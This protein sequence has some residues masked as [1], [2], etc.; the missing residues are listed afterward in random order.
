MRARR[1]GLKESGQSRPRSH[2]DASYTCLPMEQSGEQRGTPSSFL[3]DHAR[4]VG[5]IQRKEIVAGLLCAPTG[6]IKR[7][8]GET[9]RRGGSYWMPVRTC[10]SRDSE[11]DRFAMAA[12][13]A[14]E[15]ARGANVRALSR[16]LDKDSLDH[17]P[18][19]SLKG[20]NL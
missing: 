15:C 16:R 20:G 2:K 1:Y 6:F 7:A 12:F 4:D 17:C 13:Y 8:K 14:C 3:C 11:G 19:D 10:R 5:S 18:T 9:M